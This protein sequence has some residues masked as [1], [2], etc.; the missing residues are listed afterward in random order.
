MSTNRYIR[1]QVF[2]M[3]GGP[4]SG[5]WWWWSCWSG[6]AMQLIFFRF[7]TAKIEGYA[8]MDNF[9]SGLLRRVEAF[10]YGNCFANFLVLLAK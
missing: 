2:R 5:K 6:V 7:R 10:R 3:G 1:F 8:G 9:G 4:S